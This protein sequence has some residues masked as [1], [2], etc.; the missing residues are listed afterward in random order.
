MQ[1]KPVS[2]DSGHQITEAIV[3]F[4]AINYMYDETRDNKYVILLN[5]EFTEL[6]TRVVTVT[7][8]YILQ[9]TSFFNLLCF[10]NF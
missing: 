5:L 8:V 7:K 4:S 9:I 6:V 3:E 10:L 1:L 2:S